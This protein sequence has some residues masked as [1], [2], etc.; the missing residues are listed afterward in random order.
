MSLYSSGGGLW[1]T[2]LG[3]AVFVRPTPKEI[4]ARLVANMAEFHARER[5]GL[6]KSDLSCAT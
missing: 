5:S 2:K 6:M 4:M 3:T 1:E